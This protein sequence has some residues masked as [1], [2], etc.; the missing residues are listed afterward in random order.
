MRTFILRERRNLD[1][2]LA[3]IASNWEAMAKTK[4]P[5]QVDLKPEA[6]KRNLQQNRYYWQMLNQISEQSWI[7]G[8]QYSADVWHE[9]AK[10]RHIG[11]VD[12]PG[13][14]TMAMSSAD[15]NVQ[16]FADYTTKV[17]AWAQTELGVCLMDLSEPHGRVA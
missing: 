4:H 3:F 13:G 7:E 10:R 9:A 17:E 11:C 14:G 6:T 16:E 12:L 15:L 5:L 8:R 2:L 1:A